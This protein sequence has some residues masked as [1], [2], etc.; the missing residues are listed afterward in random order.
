V[1]TTA[2][3]IISLALKDAG[4]VG[5]GQTP[6]AEDTNDA[7]RRLNWML[8]QWQRKRWLVYRLV[9]TSLPMTGAQS[10]T[11]GIGGDFNVTRPEKI[12]SAYIR[13]VVGVQ[14]VDTMLTVVDSREDYNRITLKSLE[15]FPSYVFYDPGFPLGVVYP[16]PIP[17][18]IYT[19]FL[20][21]RQILESFAV[22][23]DEVDLPDEYFAALY[24]NLA[25]RLRVA[26]SLPPNDMLSRLAGDALGVIRSTNVRL[27]S[28]TMPPELY[29]RRKGYNIYSDR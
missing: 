14:N 22:P 27:P 5:V 16:W 28:M 18:V 24:Y 25:V 21:V 4:I 8:A 29:S 2:L 12:E 15:S 13:Q 26:H 9:E 3:D 11:I 17:S 6:K 1:P 7:F 19:L 23:A 20:T 10:Y